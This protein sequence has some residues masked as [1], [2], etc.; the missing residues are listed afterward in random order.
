MEERARAVAVAAVA[1]AGTAAR[2]DVVHARLEGVLALAHLSSLALVSIWSI[3]MVCIGSKLCNIWRSHA[4]RVH[5]S[6]MLVA[7]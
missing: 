7:C 4:A 5:A 2:Q 6:H 3:D 1:R